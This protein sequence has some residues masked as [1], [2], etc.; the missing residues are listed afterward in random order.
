MQEKVI[1]ILEFDKI[2]YK[3]SEFCSNPLSKEFAQSLRP[4][5]ELEQVTLLLLETSQAVRI[6]NTKGFPSFG[7]LK[8][9][10]NSLSRANA[11]SVLTTREL[12]DVADVLRVS[13]NLKSYHNQVP[14]G[15]VNTHSGHCKDL[16][17]NYDL[18]DP[19]FESLYTNKRDEERIYSCILSEEGIA[20]SASSALQSIRR[21]IHDSEQKIREK[22]NNIIHSTTY[23]KFLQENIVTIRSGRYVLPVKQ[24]FRSEVPGLVH[25]SSAS[26]ATLFIEPM[27]VVEANNTVKQLQIKEG[28]EIERIIAEL[29][30]MVGEFSEQLSKGIE[31]LARL[32]FIFAKA[33]LSLE[34]N[35][36][37]PRVNSSGFLRI[38]KARHPLLNPSCVVPI[39]LW[40][41]GGTN[42][43]IITGPNTGGKTVT[44]KTAGLLTLMAQAGLH[45]P[46]DEDSEL[47]V[48]DKIFA[49]IGDEQSIEQN[50]ST[51]SSH[52]LNIVQILQQVTSNTL[53]LLDELGSGTDPVE[54]SAL[55][56]AILEFLYNQGAVTI[57][58]THYS[59][60]KSFAINTQGF[61][62]ACC[63]FDVETLKPTYK[64]LIGVPG[65]SNA[66][67]ISGRLG[68]NSSII[69]RAKEFIS[70]DTLRFE[71]IIAE[72]QKNKL[73]S[74]K[75]LSEIEQIR[76]QCRNLQNE[77]EAKEA[78]L[79][80]Q[81]DKIIREA[82]REAKNILRQAK[83]DADRL[84][85]EIRLLAEHEES[86]RNRKA[87]Q[88]RNTLRM[89]L[90]DTEESITEPLYSVNH[91]SV[92]H[93][94]KPGDT[95]YITSLKQKGTVISG[96]DENKNIQ[97]QAG[98]IKLKIH[99]SLLKPTEEE[100]VSIQKTGSGKALSNQARS[101]S[102]ELSVRGQTLDEALDNA[103]KYLNE[104]A[105]S[106]LK[107]VT[108]IHGKGTG[109]LKNGIH[110]LLKK[111]PLVKTFRL[112]RFGEGEHGVTVVELDY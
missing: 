55:A 90:K 21:Q 22:L 47:N 87:E 12:M 80:E 32:D 45:I 83:E 33:R 37:Q 57:A 34:M 23:Q 9:I 29:S 108:I 8:D 94:Y 98:I 61:E 101:I 28:L 58:T 5:S 86:E 75:H 17:S 43:L 56:S 96:P 64:L 71:D 49:D 66:F 110:Q 69:A 30:A 62:N 25:D 84:L 19:L 102:L 67:A 95:V 112:G 54:G 44:L 52:M 41:G 73:T 104:A 31:S 2:I 88:L 105:L 13:R 20:D 65:K 77:L 82:R 15:S 6:I 100:K 97:V 35:A 111:H 72:V 51:F 10:R 11:G 4:H 39:D 99:S 59:E 48:F 76:V 109:T 14:A 70:E 18:L 42:T 40:C 16:L 85:N 68:L 50:L 78:D 106:G 26:G 63:E 81:K 74:E 36:V 89:K 107:T 53:V 38:K 3:L 24:E 46:A 91:A 92:S 60:L 1:K 79:K 27:A 7:S 103:D 93:N